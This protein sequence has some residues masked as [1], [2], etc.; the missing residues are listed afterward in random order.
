MMTAGR[1]STTPQRLACELRTSIGVHACEPQ[2][3]LDVLLCRERW[4]EVG[5]LKHHADAFAAQ[6]GPSWFTQ[7]G[8]LPWRDEYLHL[9]L[10]FQ[11]ARDTAQR[12]RSSSS[13]LCP[14]DN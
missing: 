4:E 14:D 6:A 12:G 2:G 8:Q 1:K 5:I 3:Y 10:V 11:P 13:D 9:P 7:P